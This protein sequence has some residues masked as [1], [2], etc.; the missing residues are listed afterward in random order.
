M[1]KSTLLLIP[2]LLAGILNYAIA[3]D[4]NKTVSQNTTTA[5]TA[6]KK[7]ETAVK[8][9]E[10]IKEAIEALEN[11]A[12]ALDA[13]NNNKKQEALKLLEIVTG[14]LNILIARNPELALLPISI[15]ERTIDLGADAHITKLLIKEV[16]EAINAGEIQK[17]R[18]LIHPLASEIVVTTTSLPLATYP[19]AIK[20]VAPLID[21][22]KITEAKS[23]LQLILNSVVVNKTII[24]LPPLRATV[25][26]KSAEQLIENKSRTGQENLQLK[27]LLASAKVELTRGELLGYGNK[28]SYQPIY[29]EIAK[30]E[31][32]A[33]GN[34][35]GKG[36]FDKVKDKISQL[37]K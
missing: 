4:Q 36:W 37:A 7:D 31:T 26:L 28:K 6:I 21:A 11:T 3:S 22:N 1:K 19:D 13:L 2:I 34:K 27:N 23:A 18:R 32:K 30:I 25:L 20:T 10:T 24:A 29:D 15:N 33:K 14:K 12:K 35:G 17:A 16:K 8:H 5:S 9:R